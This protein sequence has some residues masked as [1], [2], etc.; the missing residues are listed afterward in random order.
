MQWTGEGGRTKI[1]A[2]I[3]A[4]TENRK[5]EDNVYT[6]NGYANRRAYLES[7]CAE[8][9]RAMVSALSNLL[10]PTEDFDGLVT[11]LEDSSD[12]PAFF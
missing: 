9:P 4:L 12:D 2:R 11:A 5:M 10:G 7:L 8:Y 3:P 1:N 6:Q